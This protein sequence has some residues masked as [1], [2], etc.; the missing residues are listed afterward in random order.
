MAWRIILID[1]KL[2]KLF[3]KFKKEKIPGTDLLSQAGRPPSTIG[4]GGLNDRVRN[5]NG[6]GPSGMGTREIYKNFIK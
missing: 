6:C 3:Q 1:K 5:G 4:P 2:D